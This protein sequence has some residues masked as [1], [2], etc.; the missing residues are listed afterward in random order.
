VSSFWRLE[1]PIISETTGAVIMGGMWSAQ[2]ELWKSEH[3]VKAYLGGFGSGKSMILCKRAISLCLENA[4]VPIMIISPS[5]RMAKRTVLLALMTLLEGRKIKYAYNKTDSVFELTF[6]GKKGTIFIGSAEIPQTLKGSNIAA[7]LID[8]AFMCSWETIEIAMSRIRDPASKHR[9]LVLCGTP[10][11]GLGSWGYEMLFGDKKKNFDISVHEASTLENKA[12][13]KEFVESLLAAYSDEAR[14]AYVYGKY[15]NLTVGRIYPHFDSETMVMRKVLPTDPTIEICAGLDMNVD[16][17]CGV[18]FWVDPNTLC[19]HIF[20]EIHITGGCDTWQAVDA[21]W[22]DSFGRLSV[23]M[24]DPSATQR[25]TSARNGTTDATIIQTSGDRLRGK[26]F[27]LRA[28]R[29]TPPLRDRW[30]SVN[31]LCKEGKLTIDPKCIHAIKSLSRSTYDGF[32]KHDGLD[33]MADALSY[34]IHLE[35]PI[36]NKVKEMRQWY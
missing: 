32:K 7:C 1:E 31:N 23:F 12:L 21:L 26:P 6:R 2:L 30:N 19:M 8:E 3:Y 5:Y 33:H 14:D 25:K 29:R 13:P 11:D 35:D 16:P 9:E 28:A 27:A 20:S 36:K 4:P 10:E 18:L 34:R 22:A 24:P 15:A 17:F